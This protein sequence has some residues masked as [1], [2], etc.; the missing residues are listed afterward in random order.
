MVLG[1]REEKLMFPTATSVDLVLE[2]TEATSWRPT[3]ELWEITLNEGFNSC[4]NKYF[5]GAS[6]LPGSDLTT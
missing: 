4:S 6:S 5:F 1:E 3:W 2:I